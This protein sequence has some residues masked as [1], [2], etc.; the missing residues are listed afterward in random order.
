MPIRLNIEEIKEVLKFNSDNLSPSSSFEGLEFDSRNVKGGELFVALKGENT[1]GHDFVETAFTRGA[2]L[3]L[4]E[5]N[6]INSDISEDKLIRVDDSLIA[7]QKLSSYWINKLNIKK[8]AITGSM[9][10]T[11]IKE[12]TSAILLSQSIGNYSRKS[13]NNHVGVPYTL[14]QTSTDHSWLVNEMGMNHKG[15]LKSLSLLANPDIALISCIAPVHIEYFKSIKDIAKAKLEILAGVKENGTFIYNADDEVLVSAIKENN[16]KLPK[17]VLTFGKSELADFRIISTKLLG[18]KGISLEIKF[19]DEVYELS[20]P[21]LG[22][23]NAY[24]AAAAIAVAKTLSPELTKESIEN[25]CSR[26][27]PP[28]MRLNQYTLRDGRVLIDDSYNSNPVALEALINF[29]VELKKD[30]I[31][32]GFIIGDMLEL[33]TSA[34]KYHLE[35]AEKLALAKPA[36]VIACGE[37]ADLFKEQALKLNIPAYSV[38]NPKVAALTAQK[39]KSD[40]IFVKASRGI[41]LDESVAVLLERIGEVIPSPQFSDEKVFLFKS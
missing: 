12:L 5:L 16:I 6:F 31:S 27:Q 18:L 22:T 13:F 26:F 8:A 39:L 28:P 4:V 41:K 19:K 34:K 2:S 36:F 1:H 29:S 10:K 17:N 32:T 20:L 11:F 14:A 24:N 21:I 7:F 38:N 9:G 25:A 30:D 40:T 37:F 23:H 35:L 15:E 3:A 33:G